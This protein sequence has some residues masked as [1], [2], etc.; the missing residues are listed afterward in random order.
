MDISKADCTKKLQ[1]ALHKRWA[2][3]MD[4]Q[5]LTRERYNNNGY[6]ME[7]VYAMPELVVIQ[8]VNQLEDLIQQ[9]FEKPLFIYKHSINCGS[10]HNAHYSLQKFMARPQTTESFVFSMVRVND[11][12]HI[13][14]EVTN[15]FGVKH[16]SPQILLVCKGKAVWHASHQMINSMNLSNTAYHILANLS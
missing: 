6:L 7:G 11:E 15:R 9:S 1:S 10:S 3:T 13:A 2:S 8:N 4:Y 16:A 5:P 12:K 14:F